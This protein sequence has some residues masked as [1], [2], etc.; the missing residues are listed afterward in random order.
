MKPFELHPLSALAGAAALGLTLV[1]A[2]AVQTR[3]DKRVQVGSVEPFTVQGPVKVELTEPVE[4]KPAWPPR[5]E[6]MFYFLVATALPMGAEIPVAMVP[7]D[8]WLVITRADGADES[9]PLVQDVG[10]VVTTLTEANSF[11]GNGA[12]AGIAASPTAEVKFINPTVVNRG[13]LTYEVHGY[14]VDVQ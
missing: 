4:V 1:A 8:K 3:P 13:K 6:D 5:P 12:G 10:G 7:A 14:F 11:L 2:G 9:F